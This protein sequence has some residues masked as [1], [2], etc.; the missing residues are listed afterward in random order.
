MICRHVFKVISRLSDLT[1]VRMFAKGTCF[2]FMIV[3]HGYSTNIFIW[4]IL[5]FI[6]IVLESIFIKIVM[7]CRIMKEFKVC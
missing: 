3:S 4:A 6:N 5:G 2:A 1:I 7:E